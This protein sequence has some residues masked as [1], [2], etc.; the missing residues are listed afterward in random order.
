[1]P[2]ENI[3]R[4]VSDMSEFSLPCSVWPVATWADPTWVHNMISA[5]AAATANARLLIA[6]RSYGTTTVSPGRKMM[7][8]LVFPRKAC[9]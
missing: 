1:M 6:T 5:A 9:L 2:G 8:W 4:P 3:S 7:S